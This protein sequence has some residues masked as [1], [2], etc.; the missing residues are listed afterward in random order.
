MSLKIREEAYRQ[1]SACKMWTTDSLEIN[2]LAVCNSSQLVSQLVRWARSFV[3]FQLSTY[4]LILGL[5]LELG[6]FLVSNSHQ[7]NM[8]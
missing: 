3:S 4:L 5:F 7:T 8:C 1:K 2:L 6:L